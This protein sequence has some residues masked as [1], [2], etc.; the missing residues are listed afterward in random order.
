MI[1]DPASLEVSRHAR[2]AKSDS[3]DVESLLRHLVAYGSHRARLAIVRVPSPEDEARRQLDR[4]LESLK[5]ERGVHKKR[6]Q[7]LLF[8]QGIAIDVTPKLL[9]AL[10]SLRR[11][12]ERFRSS[13]SRAFVV[14]EIVSEASND[15]FAKW[16][17]SV[18]LAS[19]RELTKRL[20][21]CARS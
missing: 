6:I 13:W 5:K 20:S 15:R 2:R 8:A 21:E 19:P 11:M 7:S 9:G 14:K 17:R 12:G 3:I 10:E 1:V 4:E 16:K 18:A